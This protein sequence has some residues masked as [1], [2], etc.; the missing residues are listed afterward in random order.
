MTTMRLKPWTPAP[1]S[2]SFGHRLAPAGDPL[3]GAA[4]D[5][6]YDAKIKPELVKCEAERRGAVKTFAAVVLGGL[7]LCFLETRASM[8]FPGIGGLPIWV[9]VFTFI[10][11][12]VL[13]YLPVQKVYREAKLGVVQ[14]LCEPLGIDLR[15]RA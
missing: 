1:G 2:A 3:E 5:A 13:G 14:A 9:Y 10:G 6:I 7:V 8:F 4:F 11:A 12:G 15:P